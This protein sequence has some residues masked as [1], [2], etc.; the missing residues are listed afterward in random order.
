[1]TKDIPENYLDKLQEDYIKSWPN[2]CTKCNGWGYT[3]KHDPTSFE[4]ELSPCH[5]CVCKNQCPRCRQ[6]T[7]D[8]NQDDCSNCNW[9]LEGGFPTW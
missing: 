3:E 8:D 7:L 6:E 9:D 4:P 5:E 1:M 2:Y